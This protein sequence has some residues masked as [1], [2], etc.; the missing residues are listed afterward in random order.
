MKTGLQYIEG[1]T[2]FFNDDG[3]MQTG[4]VSNVEEADGDTFNYYFNTKNSGKGQGFTEEICQVETMTLNCYRYVFF[5]RSRFVE[6]ETDKVQQIEVEKMS[7]FEFWI[8][9]GNCSNV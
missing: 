1:H 4:K 9:F 2:Y 7:A 6:E 5:S 3:Y 8:I